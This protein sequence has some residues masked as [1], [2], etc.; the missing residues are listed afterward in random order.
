MAY[1]PTVFDQVRLVLVKYLTTL[2]RLRI[3]M[4]GLQYH[5]YCFNLRLSVQNDFVR[6]IQL[7]KHHVV[8]YIIIFYQ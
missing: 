4:G 1:L 6:L 2:Q 5:K 7:S 3:E 8:S